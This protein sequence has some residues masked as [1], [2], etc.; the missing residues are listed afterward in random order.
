M[1]ERHKTREWEVLCE[2]R[3]KLLEWLFHIEKQK[4]LYQSLSHKQNVVFHYSKRILSKN[5]I[6]FRHLTIWTENE[7]SLWIKVW[8]DEKKALFYDLMFL[9]DYKELMFVKN[10]EIL[11]QYHTD[12]ISSS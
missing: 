3:N 8:I 4:I 5:I 10:K 9:T 6:F 11:I 1:R 12:R 2:C 7:I